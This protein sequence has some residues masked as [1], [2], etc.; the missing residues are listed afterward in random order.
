M[1][2]Q[3]SISSRRMGKELENNGGSSTLV[4]IGAI[5]RTDQEFEA[6]RREEQ[7]KWRGLRAAV[8]RK[9]LEL[10]KPLFGKNSAR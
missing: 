7:R 6:F 9:R 4:L 5:Q 1:A 10:G 2:V 3:I 8:Y